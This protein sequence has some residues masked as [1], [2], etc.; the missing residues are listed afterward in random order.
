MS[1]TSREERKES[2]L[3]SFREGRHA[4]SVDREAELAKIERKRTS[5][6]ISDI[7][8]ML[9]GPKKGGKELLDL[10]YSAGKGGDASL[11]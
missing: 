4:R 3:R 9:V 10:C 2:H 1:P 6:S 7:Y 5:A 8:I 11:E